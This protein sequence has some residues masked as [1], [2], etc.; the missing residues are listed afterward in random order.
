MTFTAPEKQFNLFLD[1]VRVP[2]GVTTLAHTRSASRAA[3]RAA[4]SG[5]TSP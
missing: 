3:T 2:A 5:P 1:D 4:P